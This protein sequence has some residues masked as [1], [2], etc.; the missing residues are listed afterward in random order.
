M[1][2]RERSDHRGITAPA[3]MLG[4]TC[5][6][7]LELPSKT[8]PSLS[9]RLASTTFLAA[10][11]GSLQHFKRSLPGAVLRH[12][13]RPRPCCSRTELQV[14]RSQPPSISHGACVRTSV[15]ICSGGNCFL[16]ALKSRVIQGEM[17]N[18]SDRF[19]FLTA[20]PLQR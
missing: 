6:R 8:E 2:G 3:S 15:I 4:V 7:R 5:M 16:M 17:W 13:R 14:W 9:S 18:H 11:C 10:S 1:R 12:S 20:W 19:S